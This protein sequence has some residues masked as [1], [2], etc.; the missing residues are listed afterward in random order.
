MEEWKNIPMYPN[1]QASNIGNIRS[2][3][4]YDTLGRLKHGVQKKFKKHRNG[5]LCV[6]LYHK[7][8]VLVHRLVALA[9]LGVGNNGLEVNHKDGNKQNNN[10]ENLEWVT[11]SENQKHRYESLGKVKE[12]QIR[13]ISERSKHLKM[14]TRAKVPKSWLDS[15]MSLKEISLL[16][17]VSISTI[18]RM[19]NG[20]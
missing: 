1:Y 2:V 8:V 3:T 19:R 17:G 4:H 7:N 14:S 20:K 6:T 15:D 9:F 16:T 13:S 18:S 10:V 12:S 11:K 5:Y